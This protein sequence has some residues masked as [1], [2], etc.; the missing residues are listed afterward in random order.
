MLQH[1]HQHAFTP[2]PLQ[3]FASGIPAAPTGTQDCNFITHLPRGTSRQS[4][5]PVTA[6][7]NTT[8]KS[9]NSTGRWGALHVCIAWKI[10][11]KERLKKMQ[12]T[13]DY[14]AII[15]PD[16]VQQ[17]ESDASS[18]RPSNLDPPCEHL[19]S[20]PS[21]LHTSSLAPCHS[22]TSKREDL[23]EHQHPLWKE[24][25]DEKEKHRSQQINKT[26]DLPLKDKSVDQTAGLDGRLGSSTDRKRQLECNGLLK[27]KK[28]RQETV[29]DH[30]DSSHIKSSEPISDFSAVYPHSNTSNATRAP[31]GLS[32]YPGAELNPY[33]TMWDCNKRMDLYCRQNILKDYSFKTCK[34]IRTPPAAQRP[35]DA[36]NAYS[37]TPLYFPL[38]L[39]EQETVYHRERESLHSQQQ[40]CPFYCGRYQLPYPCFLQTPHLRH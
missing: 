19:G 35:G 23:D 33:Q 26:K 24:K 21:D 13:P 25:V 29:G 7:H 2:Y 15:L 28:A 3:P 37:S 39:R 22:D 6:F 1:A 12:Q 11:Y 27:V 5:A 34:V 20:L 31:C 32:S 4:F 14:P 17:K 10:Y 30:F 36:F 9:F 40:H 16:K 18:C 38:A 8:Q